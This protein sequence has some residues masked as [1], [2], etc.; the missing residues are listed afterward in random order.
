L[1][2]G[3]G[4]GAGALPH[5]LRALQHRNFRIYFLGQA[6]SIFG[7]WMQQVAMTWLVYRLTGSSVLLGT[8]AFVSLAPQLLVGPFAGA[9]SDRHD[10]R[11]MLLVV[12][13][14]MMAQAVILTILTWTGLIHVALVVTLAAALGV[15]NAFETPLRQS[16]I[17][18]MV[19]DAEALPNA[20]ALNAMLFNIGR[21][22]APPIA[23]LLL[24]V[25]SEATCFAIN[26][27]SFLVLI[28]A[29]RRMDFAKHVPRKAALGHLFR[30][31][32][33]Y[34]RRTHAVRT[35][36]TMLV[37]TNL[38]AS[39][40][41]VLLPLIA[42][43]T[44][45]GGSVTLGWLWGAAGLGAVV[46]TLLLATHRSSRTIVMAI[47]AGVVLCVIAMAALGASTLVMASVGAMCLLGFGISVAN[48][49]TN[50]VL[51]ALAPDAMRG[52]VVSLFTAIRFG[53]DA[54][55]G[56]IAGLL[57]AG[58]GFANTLYVGAGLELLGACWFATHLSELKKGT[59]LGATHQD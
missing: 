54:V 25:V 35:L 49:G 17:S 59:A 5:A 29:V 6:A 10:K 1:K 27:V 46:S 34:A 4:A 9:W 16:L 52:R 41:S 15:L 33:A 38:T 18:R 24:A 43:Q 48:V 47:L 37:L 51:Q 31:G 11:R 39:S 13:S 40:Y 23:G 45:G 3:A 58:F 20:L 57:A 14:L 55:G 56:L 50:I 2:S 12:E 30:E 19:T 7:S 28:A 32:L 8:T 44:L 53:F 36:L 42:T 22:L 21:F 26:A